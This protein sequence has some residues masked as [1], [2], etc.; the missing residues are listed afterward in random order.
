VTREPSA[1]RRGRLLRRWREGRTGPLGLALAPAAWV[2]RAGALVREGAYARGW[3]SRGR[4]RCPV[5]SIGNL[6]VGGTGKTPAVEMVARWLTDEGRRVAIV[7]RGYGRRPAAPVEVVS[8]GGAPRLSAERAGDEPVLLARRLPG[9]AVVV[10]ADR[11]EAGRWTVTNLRPDVVVLDDGFQQRRLLKDVEIVCLDA[12]APWG[13]GG[14][15]PR[16]TL[17]E[18]PSALAR[19]HLVIV[20][21]ADPRRSLAGLL[22]EIRHYAGSAPCLFT[23]Y[24]AEDLEDLRSDGRAPVDALRDRS[25]L[26]FAGIAAPERLGETLVAHGAIVRDV[27]AFPDHHG[28]GRGD[29]EAVARRARMVGAGMLVTTEKD[30][31]RLAG[32]GGVIAAA[33][34]S[35]AV[36]LDGE[37]PLPLFALRVRLAPVPGVPVVPGRG[38]TLDR[39]RS[40]DAWRAELRARLED[41]GRQTPSGT[42]R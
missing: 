36:R 1:V 20:T 10:G 16:G 27:V 22:D 3:L 32:P 11:L 40:I 35:A 28:Y 12:R 37:A 34:A 4:L 17:R 39:S 21:R 7:S 26:A 33:A 24:A 31:V 13:P 15:F 8:D 29:L 42:S 5:V 14:L 9:V 30:A 23:E 41:A 25:V 18:P 6:T 19:A 2:Y 38:A